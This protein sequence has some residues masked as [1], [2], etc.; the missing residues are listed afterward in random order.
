MAR[1]TNT[2]PVPINM[3]LSGDVV[4]VIKRSK[5]MSKGESASRKTA[6]KTKRAQQILAEGVLL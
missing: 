1:I 6:A 3:D 5:P 2:A 4:F